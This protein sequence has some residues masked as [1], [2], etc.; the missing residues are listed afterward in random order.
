MTKQVIH[1]EKTSRGA[2][3]KRRISRRWRRE[4]L[5]VLGQKVVGETHDCLVASR[6]W[7]A[8]TFPEMTGKSLIA[9]VSS[10]S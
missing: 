4:R 3:G 10:S 1:T 6:A 2:A 7:Y 5:E 8:R 9:L